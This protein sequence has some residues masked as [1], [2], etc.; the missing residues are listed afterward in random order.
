MAISPPRTA[1]ISSSLFLVRSSPSKRISP[2]SI[3]PGGSISRRIEKPITDFPPPDSPTR[4][5]TSPFAHVETHAIDRLHQAAEGM[6]MGF[7]PADIEQRFTHRASLFMLH[8][9]RGLSSSRRKSPNKLMPK[10][11]NMMNRPGKAEVHQIPENRTSKPS[12]TNS[13]RRGLGDWDADAEEAQGGF[14]ED[15]GADLDGGHHDERRHARS[16]GHDA[17]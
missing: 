6:E 3:R 16:A 5:T 8:R 15:E 14:D 9:R 7:Q 13:P 17:R 1:R 2:A 11:R 10:T 12:F 4:P